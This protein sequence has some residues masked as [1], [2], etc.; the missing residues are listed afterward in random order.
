M[1]GTGVGLFV[2]DFLIRPFA[3]IWEKMPTVML[4]LCIILYAIIGYAVL[5]SAWLADQHN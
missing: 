5:K 4:V 1:P 2:I 3:K